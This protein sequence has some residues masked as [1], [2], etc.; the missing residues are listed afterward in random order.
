VTRTITAALIGLAVACFAGAL[1]L[2]SVGT[3]FV[4]AVAFCILVGITAALAYVIA[5]RV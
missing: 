2:G 5:G 4:A 1:V 3:T